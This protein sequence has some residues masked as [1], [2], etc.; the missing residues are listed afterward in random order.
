MI[1]DYSEGSLPEDQSIWHYCQFAEFVS[2]LQRQ[3]LWFSRLGCLRD[4]FEGR[5]ERTYK[6]RLRENSEAHTRKSCANCWTIDHEESELMWYA[7]APTFGVVIRS[8]KSRLKASFM[9]PEVD[10][11]VIGTVEYGTDWSKAPSSQPYAAAFKKRRHF[12]REQEL[13]AVIPYEY[14]YKHGTMI[15]P[16]HAGTL[17]PARLVLLIDEVW[18]APNSPDWFTEVVE[19]DLVKYG[20]CSIRVKRRA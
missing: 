11:I 18:V 1:T 19:L 15:E 16:A 6:S 14:E 2:I 5:S 17:V 13:R 8:T 10:R 4:P 3:A 20:Y 7:Y 9:P 12:Q